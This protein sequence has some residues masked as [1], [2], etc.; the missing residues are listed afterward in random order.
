MV[1][2]GELPQAL[3]FVD[4]ETDSLPVEESP[5]ELAQLLELGHAEYWQRRGGEYVKRG[6]LD[7]YDKPEVFWQ[8]V[9][10]KT[11]AKGR[12]WVV[13]HNMGG[14]DAAVLALG[15]NLSALGYDVVK[16]VLALPPFLIDA[17][18]SED[19]RS[20]RIV[21]SLNWFRV[22]LAELGDRY[23][24]PKLDMSDLAARCRRDVEILRTAVLA[25]IQFVEDEDLGTFRPTI[26][27][28]ALTA[29]QHRFQVREG[30]NRPMTYRAP[31]ITELERQAYVGGRVEAWRL[32]TIRELPAY[33]VDVNS[34][35][36]SVMFTEAYPVRY[37]QSRQRPALGWVQGQLDAG[38]GVIAQALLVTDQ[39]AYPLRQGDRLT[40]P[41]GRFWAAL[42][43]P[44]LAYALAAGHVR[45]FGVVH[46]YHLAPMF[47]G[48]VEYWQNRRLNYQ[49]SG[50][51]AMAQLCKDFLTHLYGKFGQRAAAWGP[52][53]DQ[54]VEYAAWDNGL[55]DISVSTPDDR[56]RRRLQ[57]RR[58]EAHI[59][60]SQ[61]GGG[62][63]GHSMPAVAA[64]V[65]AH[66]R[67][68]LWAATLAVGQEHVLY[69]DTDSLILTQAGYMNLRAAGLDGPGL[70]DW[71][72]V[73]TIE[74]EL[75]IHG[76]K[77]YVVDGRV[78]RKGVRK[79][80]EQVG[81][82]AYRQTQFVTL[83][84]AMQ[85]GH[86]DQGRTRQVTKTLTR[87]YLKGTPLPDG[88]VVPLFVVD[89]DEKE[90]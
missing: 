47:R 55:A 74:S 34:M 40:F 23:G 86:Q 84:G 24:L 14:F 35:Y 25:W 53:E 81:P 75:T 41:I 90:S 30:P 46:T 68:K 38:Y 67:A 22:P 15:A 19:G 9:H 83:L 36:A 79:D 16:L 39:N 64:H 66:A 50:D 32:G 82:N 72:L 52:P 87:Q 8:W 28:Q 26:A 10:H 45:R 11:R 6:S 58:F 29:Y 77:D 49:D 27:G 7:F 12:T 65:A 51:P 20:L 37:L 78:T 31:A 63:V 76:L 48:W 88:T 18:R 62:E 57:L 44:E 70:G 69:M 5:G 89:D 13:A 61:P 21:D 71:R 73:T 42:T 2:V 33:Q 3:I 85:A 1:T 43:T 56:E 59:E 60:Q 54:L 17:R 80:A 4:T